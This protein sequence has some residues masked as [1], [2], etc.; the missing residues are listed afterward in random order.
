MVSS[1]LFCACSVMGE[2]SAQWAAYTKISNVRSN[3]CA[4]GMEKQR[5]MFTEISPDREFNLSKTEHLI[6]ITENELENL[7]S[8]TAEELGPFITAIASTQ[9]QSSVE[10]LVDAAKGVAEKKD[11]TDF[12]LI[13]PSYFFEEQ[14]D[15]LDLE[16]IPSFFLE[17][18]DESVNCDPQEVQ[19]IPNSNNSNCIKGSL[20]EIVFSKWIRVFNNHNQLTMRVSCLNLKLLKELMLNYHQLSG[21]N[22]FTLLLANTRMYFDRGKGFQLIKGNSYF[23][24][25]YSLCSYKVNSDLFIL[26]MDFF[27]FIGD[28]ALCFYVTASG[29]LVLAVCSL[30]MAY[31]KENFMHMLVIKHGY[32]SYSLFP[33]S[34]VLMF[35]QKS[36]YGD[37]GKLLVK[38]SQRNIIFENTLYSLVDKYYLEYVNELIGQHGYP[39][40]LFFE[41]SIVVVLAKE[42]EKGDGCQLLA[43]NLHQDG[44]GVVAHGFYSCC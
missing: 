41:G 12:E 11:E 1:S 27:D 31:Y 5:L 33:N 40:A 15:S 18:L 26:L 43:Q 28:Y 6:S 20:T 29:S 25:K 10:Q 2:L 42:V 8:T 21:K 30:L 35:L 7:I 39:S 3:L 34:V 36:D 9:P 19:L 22:R 13:I 38:M 24:D 4:L 14:D 44:V 17:E 23:S 16:L 32:A 37:S